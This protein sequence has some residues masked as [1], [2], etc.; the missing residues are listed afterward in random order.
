[1]AAATFRILTR[2]LREFVWTT[3]SFAVEIGEDMSS[4]KE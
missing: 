3:T 1:M 2:W 4:S